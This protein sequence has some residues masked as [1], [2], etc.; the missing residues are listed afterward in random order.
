MRRGI[1]C[2]QRPTRSS[3]SSKISM[4]YVDVTPAL[5]VAQSLDGV[6]ARGLPRGP[7]SEDYADGRGD[8]YADEYRPERDEG[9]ERR[10][11]VREKARRLSDNE[12][13]ESAE[14]G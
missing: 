12:P 7:E 13:R 9:R 4:F 8:A 14:G 5:L 1:G 11:T 2:T 10:V 6:E 3:P